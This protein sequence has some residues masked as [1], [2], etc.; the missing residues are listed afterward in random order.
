MP[1]STVV[2]GGMLKAFPTYEKILV[3]TRKSSKAR[4]TLNFSIKFK[5]FSDCYLRPNFDS[6]YL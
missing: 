5:R 2:P 4:K 3:M 1:T 6:E